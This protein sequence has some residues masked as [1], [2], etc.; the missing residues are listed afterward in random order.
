MAA[1][2]RVSNSSRNRGS[3]ESMVTIK[4]LNFLL[5][6]VSTICVFISDR[7]HHLTSLERFDYF[8]LILFLLPETWKC[9]EHEKQINHKIIQPKKGETGHAAIKMKQYKLECYVEKQRRITSPCGTVYLKEKEGGRM[10]SFMLQT[11]ANNHLNCRQGEERKQVE[12]FNFYGRNHHKRRKV[13]G[14]SDKKEHGV[15]AWWN[16]GA[17]GLR[18]MKKKDAKEKEVNQKENESPSS[19]VAPRYH[20]LCR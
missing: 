18:R 11:W 9:V 6:N 15:H 5:D 19:S 3:H 10:R 17:V 4:S 2:Q 16:Y 7:A 20:L 14:C 1:R 8:N 12:L 13:V